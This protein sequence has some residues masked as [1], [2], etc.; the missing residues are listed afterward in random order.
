MTVERRMRVRLKLFITSL[1]LAAC[2]ALAVSQASAGGPARQTKD[3][4]TAPRALNGQERGGK[5][6]TCV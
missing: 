3:A 4:A 6:L 1:C 2:A 5:E